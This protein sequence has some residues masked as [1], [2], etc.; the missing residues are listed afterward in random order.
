LAMKRTKFRAWVICEA[1]RDAA[2]YFRK[3]RCPVGP[4]TTDWVTEAWADIR[5]DLKLTP[6]V[7]EVLWPAYWE[8]FSQETER[9]ATKPGRCQ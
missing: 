3:F 4:N 6:E 1:H 5:H 9:L 2:A 7:A 8:A